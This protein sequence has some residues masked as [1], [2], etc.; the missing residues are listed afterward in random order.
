MAKKSDDTRALR[1]ARDQP[2]TR[3]RSA[4]IDA[5]PRAWAVTEAAMEGA[6]K[7]QD[8][9]R[10]ALSADEW[11]QYANPTTR[12]AMKRARERQDEARKTLLGRAEPAP[13][14][15]TRSAGTE[16]QVP[17]KPTLEA[18]KP[19]VAVA[20]V[21]RTSIGVMSRSSAD[22]LADSRST[23][24]VARPQPRRNILSSPIDSAVGGTDGSVDAVFGAL[25]EMALNERPPFNGV[26][27]KGGL[28][29][30]DSR[31]N[32]RV[33]TRGALQKRLKRRAT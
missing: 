6:R 24:P 21:V 9:G 18:A 1:R 29:Y 28:M 12:A 8:E 10:K 13:R 2:L 4:R 20:T 32:S 16:V 15:F 26:A 17:E 33:L 23:G 27:G 3:S 11:M 30:T 25:R 14:T 22:A 19:Q 7:R 31:N 5:D